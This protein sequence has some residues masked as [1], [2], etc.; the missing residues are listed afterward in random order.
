MPCARPLFREVLRAD[1]WSHDR[2]R[3]S[4]VFGAGTISSRS[5]LRDS[6]SK[7]VSV[8]IGGNMRKG[9]NTDAQ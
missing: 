7:E 2:R 8:V 9:T 6:K 1:L 5:N 3:G 4:V